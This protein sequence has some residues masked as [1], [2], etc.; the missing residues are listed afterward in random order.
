MSLKKELVEFISEEEI[1]AM[2]DELAKQITDEYRGQQLTL[3]C[4][5]KGSILFMSDLIK[6]LNPDTTVNFVHLTS[7][8]GESVKIHLD[9]QE[10][11]TCLLYTSDAADE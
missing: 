6:R 11:I 7:P 8:K 9:I 5:L 3:V 1:S 2:V 4:P 10:D